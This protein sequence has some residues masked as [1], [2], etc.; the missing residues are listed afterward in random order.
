[1]Q[2]AS[3]F[4]PHFCPQGLQ[5][6]GYQA[7]FVG[8]GLPSPKRIPIFAGLTEEMG[9][10]TSKDFLPKVARASKEGG[11]RLLT[12]SVISSIFYIFYSLG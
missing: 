9:F 12:P 11:D 7:I 8:I 4:T 1:M 3:F 2:Q 5:E 6:E 10:Y